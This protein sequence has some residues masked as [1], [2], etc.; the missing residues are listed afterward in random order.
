[1][2]ISELASRYNLPT[3]TIRYYVNMGLLVPNSKGKQYSFNEEDATD[4]ELLLKLKGFGLSLSET[5]Q[6]LSIRRNS[7]FI[8]ESDSTHYRDILSEHLTKLEE[9]DRHIHNMIEAVKEELNLNY[10]L[11][12]LNKSKN[13]ATGVSLRFLSYLYC[14][15]CN[16]PLDVSNMQITDQH[17]TSALLHCTCGYEARITDGI[18]YVDSDAELSGEVI[19]SGRRF[20]TESPAPLVSLYQKGHNWLVNRLNSI[21]DEHQIIIEPLN[22]TCCFLFPNIKKLNQSHLYIFTDKHAEVI[23]QYKKALEVLAPNADILYIVDPTH[24]YP[25]KKCCITTFIDYAATAEYL[26]YEP[27]GSFFD[28]IAPYLCRD[29]NIIGGLFHFPWGSRT[30]KQFLSQFPNAQKETMNLVSFKN[31]M[32]RH[33][34]KLIAEED[35]GNVTDTGGV[36]W[37]FSF[38][39]LGEPLSLHTFHY[40]YRR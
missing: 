37:A 30:H 18:V 3:Q 1:M 38:H 24:K 39:K 17:I 13:T 34:T 26:T 31:M 6:I 22:N 15:H 33:T 10:T 29:A 11:T 7:E 14:P 35:I 32:N 23:E 25:L 28:C 16:K 2:K 21:S 27:S 40:T 4:L 36:N 19:D 9:Q 12:L 20:Y 5:H 8:T